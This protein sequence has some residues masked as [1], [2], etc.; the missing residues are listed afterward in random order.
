MTADKEREGLNMSEN[1]SQLGLKCSEDREGNAFWTCGFVDIQVTSAR[2]TENELT[3]A[4][5]HFLHA[6]GIVLS[7]VEGSF[8]LNMSKSGLEL[9]QRSYSSH[10]KDHS[11]LSCLFH[12]TSF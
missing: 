2:K 5:K 3:F 4:C 6:G 1:T 8:A 10:S 11:T 9:V 12:A 7:T